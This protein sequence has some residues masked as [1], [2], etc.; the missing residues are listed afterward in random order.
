[1]TYTKVVILTLDNNEL[2]LLT[3]TNP[4]SVRQLEFFRGAIDAKLPGIFQGKWKTG[5][6]VEY[7]VQHYSLFVLGIYSVSLTRVCTDII[8]ADH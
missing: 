8:R 3:S 7:F 4:L 1:M 5:R 2:F 6:Q